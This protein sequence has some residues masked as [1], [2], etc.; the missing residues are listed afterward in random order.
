M[1]N[2][3]GRW[4]FRAD[5]GTTGTELWITDGTAAGTYLLKDIN[6]GLGWSSPD[7]FAALGNGLVLFQADD[8]TTG[9]ELWI[10][11]GT[12]AGTQLLK[13]IR[14]GTGS[15]SPSQ[16]TALGN[17]LV[18]FQ[19]NDG[20]SG[21]EL[22]VTDG[23]A[24]GT[25]LLKDIR[26]GTGSSSPTQF[27][28]LGN[29]QALFTASDATHGT[30]LWITDGTAAGTLLL[31][32]IRSG[33][34]SSLPSQFTV[35]GNGQVLFTASDATHGTELWITDGTAAG[36][37]L[38]KDI[39]SGSS[40]SAPLE[41]TALGNGQ[42]VFRTNNGVNGYELWITDGTAA[43]TQLLR[44]IRPGASSSSPAG[45]TALGNGQLLFRAN[46]GTAGSELWITDGTA[47]GTQMLKDIVAGTGSS[48]PS[49]FAALGNGLVLFVATDDTN[50]Y[51]LWVTDGTAA[52]TQM[53]KDINTGPNSSVPT[54]FTAL[55]NGQAIFQAQDG[56][57]GVELWI[58]D[59]TVAGTQRLKDIYPGT[60]DSFPSV[61]FRLPSP[62][63][64]P[65]L[66]GTPATLPN[67]TEDQTYT[68]N[69]VA[70][71]QGYSDPDGD[72][73]QVGGLLASQGSLTDNGD[74]TWTFT[75]PAD[76]FGPVTI[77]YIVSDGNG[78]SVSASLQLVL[79][80]VN[81]APTLANALVDQN[82][83]ED[84]VFSFQVPANAFADVDAGDTLTFSATL[85][86]GSPLPAWLS[87]DAATRT[88]SG[89]PTN[90]DVGTLSLKVTAT[91]SAGVFVSDTF[92]LVIANTNDAPTLTNAIADQ[93]AT[94]DAAFSFTFAADTFADVD[95]GDTLT[96]SATLADGSP[97]PAWLSFDPGTRTFSGSP[98]N[99]GIISVRVT[100]TDSAGAQIS[101][102][103]DLVVANIN[104]APT[105]ANAIGDQNAT[106]E[107]AFSFTF[108]AD[109]FTDV[110]L[111]DTLTY[112]A[113]L[114]DGSPLPAWLSF[115]PGTR[116][117]TGT[118]ANGDVGTLTLKVT[119]TD[120]TGALVSDTFDLV[121]ANTNDAP[122]LTNAIADQ[123]ATEGTAFSFTF[124]ADTFADVDLGDTLAYS[125]TLADGSP[126]PA[127]L[128]FDPGTRTFTGTPANGDVGTLSLKVTATDST[129][130]LVSDTF[131]LVIANT[132]DSPTLANAIADQNATEDA[133]F[134]FTF[135]A[136]T[137][138]DVD[139]GDTLTYT[140][141]LV[142]GAALP[143][144]LSFDAATRTFSGSPGNDDVGTLSITVTATDSAGAQVSDTFDLAIA[145]VNDPALIGG[146]LNGTLTEDAVDNS[147]A[148]TLTISDVDSPATFQAVTTPTTS[149]QGYGTFTLTAAGTWTYVLNNSHP[150]VDALATGQQLTDSFTVVA[151]DGTT[152]SITITID[153]NTDITG[154]PPTDIRWT[155]SPPANGA[156]PQGGE[157]LGTLTTTD[158]DSSAFT[159]ALL[160]GSSVGFSIN[161]GVVSRA[162]ALT[163]ST[164]YQL[165]VQT[166]DDTGLSY[167]ETF[168]IRT[169]TGGNNTQN[170]GGSD[171]VIYGAGGNDT[172][173]G[174]SG[175]DSLF[176][177]AGDDILSG[178]LG[179]DTLHY[180]VGEGND[181]LQGNAGTDRLLVTGSSAD[182]SLAVQLDASGLVSQVAGSTVATIE[183]IHLDLG[184]GVDTLSYAGTTTAVSVNLS[185]GSA[186]GFSSISGLENVTGGDGADMLTGDAN[187]NVLFGGAGADTIDFG[188]GNDDVKDRAVYS[189]ANEGGDGEVI[190]RFDSTGTAAE[191]DSIDLT[192]T[193]RALLD[194]DGN[195]TLSF[196]NSET[197]NN[198]NTAANLASIEAL[199]LR[200]S[201]NDGVS[202]ANLTNA[203]AVAAEFNAEFNLTVTQGEQTLLLLNDNTGGS[204]Q[205]ALWLYTEAS[206]GTSL[207]NPISAIELTLVGVIEANAP[208]LMSQI[209]LT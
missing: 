60:E 165:I 104:D 146:T 190:R 195:G 81:D 28:A 103:F 50:G 84:A 142:G 155:G 32:D 177:G 192:G 131:D 168:V 96:Y 188:L 49:D 183:E 40:S 95:L 136:D 51:E 13:D 65:V 7:G 68:L 19:A 199:Y 182:D 11:D 172:I 119:A 44:D 79:D 173:N 41:F 174:S 185:T 89:M 204:H 91:D 8:G 170:G 86:D 30:E 120:S 102:T 25:Q 57:T 26:S 208:V 46:D 58:T 70:L 35:L 15:S 105:L 200:G 43:G 207:D 55:G 98:D 179:N 153:G 123:N 52:G 92:G 48:S 129:G 147:V 202:T 88:F 152:Q 97:L 113:T 64:P 148:G 157:V 10:T 111:G 171:D 99:G 24:A 125:T 124:A 127:W 59:G 156:L 169:G 54:Y 189:D 186:T 36:T 38:L 154:L 128:S 76:Y 63:E 5:D 16:F 71:L 37:Q 161:N 178:G 209:A 187:A 118:P 101:D 115:D 4:L 17:G 184:A 162:G 203:A 94:E 110:D 144:W 67:G 27:T 47:A 74:G 34:G 82:A 163:A 193:L 140:A 205:S 18:L 121:I 108:A 135:A 176:G 6:P 45:F 12:T 73:L 196:R 114:A 132:N 100:A 14:L 130:A 107:A 201:G 122:T 83:S 66:D 137:F 22:W 42:W 145:N 175:D 181:T 151:A 197:A 21:F 206:P 1:P 138:A 80:P 106:E 2:Q 9:T 93:N 3:T 141:T 31:K 77:T 69:A 116:T 72:T 160:P 139:L 85:A 134:S 180:T 109:T 87:F 167:T 23:T 112:S 149:D 39:N 150:A 56:P 53:L 61:F 198:S 164:T 20:A 75:P 62:N 133:A 33:T 117:F 191:I 194:T 90:D 158:P 78:G 126:L 143:A 29:G 166:T 159:Y